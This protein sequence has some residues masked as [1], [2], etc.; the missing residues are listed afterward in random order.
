MMVERQ[1]LK[2][3]LNGAEVE[4]K[5]LGEV[6]KYEQQ[7]KYQVVTKKYSDNFDTPVLTAGKTFILG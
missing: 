7:I 4:W 5:S 2:K 6:T 1:F 3:L